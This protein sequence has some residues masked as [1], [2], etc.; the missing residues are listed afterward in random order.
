MD[1]DGKFTLF[2]VI[3]NHQFFSMK[4]ERETT[5]TFNPEGP[6]SLW[7]MIS[8]VG[9]RLLWYRVVIDSLIITPQALQNS[10]RL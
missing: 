8:M 2:I 4:R 3:L 9:A 10:K 1:I 7:G 5:I 6:T